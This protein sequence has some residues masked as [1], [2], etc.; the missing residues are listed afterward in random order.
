MDTAEYAFITGT[1]T[2]TGIGNPGEVGY[3]PAD[4]RTFEQA[5][6]DDP[7]GGTA[8]IREEHPSPL[9]HDVLEWVT[10]RTDPNTQ[11]LPSTFLYQFLYQRRVYGKESVNRAYAEAF[12]RQ[13]KC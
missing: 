2:T 4:P 12:L 6:R 5:M 9:N 8:S 3:T 11:F 7:V 1:I 13:R 10:R